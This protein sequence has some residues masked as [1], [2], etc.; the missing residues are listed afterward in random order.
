MNALNDNLVDFILI[1]KFEII[2]KNKNVLGDPIKRTER[3]NHSVEKFQIFDPCL[4][5][6]AKSRKKLI[7][8][9]PVLFIRSSNGS[10]Q[11][12]YL[13][14]DSYRRSSMVT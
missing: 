11:E 12:N 4:N 2:Q 1:S 6:E 10:Q 7:D 3:V 9:D 8:L 14:G 13:K 5:E